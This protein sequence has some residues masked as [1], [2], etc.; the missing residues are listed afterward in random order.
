V[1][2]GF[3]LPDERESDESTRHPDFLVLLHPA[4]PTRVDPSE[5]LRDGY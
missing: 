5:E 4:G 1:N 3:N 2:H